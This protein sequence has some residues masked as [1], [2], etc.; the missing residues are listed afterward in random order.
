[1]PKTKTRT[2]W[3]CQQCGYVSVKSYGRC[4]DCGEWD[5]F[6]ETIETR[7]S[8][9]SSLAALA[10]SSQPQKISQIV[11]D[12]FA[13]IPVPMNEFSR[14]LGGGIVPGSLVLIGGEPGIGKSTLLLQIAA[15]LAQSGGAVLYVSGEE[16]VQQMK[17][18]AERLGL[19]PDSLYLLTETNLDEIIATS[20]T[21]NPGSSSSIPSRRSI[22]K[23]WRARPGASRRCANPP[24]A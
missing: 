21:S 2:Q 13:R 14:V 15:T 19:K 23:I 12:G 24:R 3:V 17:M 4:P 20:R 7:A 11:T 16:S 18:R 8:S 10:P 1:M 6:V 9:K 22:L 5:S